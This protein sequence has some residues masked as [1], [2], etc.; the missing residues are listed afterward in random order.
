MTGQPERKSRAKE[1]PVL[2][3]TFTPPGGVTRRFEF[4]QLDDELT[5]LEAELIE[6][7][8]GKQWDAFMGWAL[9]LTNGSFRALRVLLWVLLRRETPKLELAE[10]D[11]PVSAL[12]FETIE[13]ESEPEAEGKDGDGDSATNSP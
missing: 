7:A 2:R 1:I 13:D 4:E 11:F 9:Q 5:A 8:G 3:L 6:D 10:L 12:G